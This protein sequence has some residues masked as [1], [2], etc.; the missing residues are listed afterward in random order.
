MRRL[1]LVNNSDGEREVDNNNNTPVYEFGSTERLFI[2]SLSQSVPW[3]ASGGKSNS[4]FCKTLDDRFVVK[5]VTNREFDM[6]LD[7]AGLYFQHM[8]SQ[9]SA[10]VQILG[11]YQVRINKPKK[12]YDDG[13]SDTSNY[14]KTSRRTQCV[15]VM[16]NVFYGAMMNSMEVFDL[17]GKIRHCSREKLL[18]MEMAEQN[19]RKLLRSKWKLW[20]SGTRCTPPPKDM[21]EQRITPVRYDGDLMNLTR[22]LPVPLKEIDMERLRN[23]ISSDGDFFLVGEAV[24]YSLLVGINA[25]MH[26]ITIGIVDYMHSY[27]LLK[28]LEFLGKSVTGE[29][30]IKPPPQY[31]N[32]FLNGIEKYFISVPEDEN[33]VLNDE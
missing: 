2:Q 23:R 26:T 15:V 9:Q 1:L 25:E 28:R 33:D 11:A 22:G 24:D 12:Y 20:R 16:G 7:V 31:Y 10:L 6:F 14:D 32:R 27:D 5:C 8:S 17:K 19:R 13:S 4:S 18:K 21:N 30:T 29:S 3:A